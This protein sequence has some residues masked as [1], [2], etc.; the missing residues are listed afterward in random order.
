MYI[1]NKFKKMVC[2]CF[3]LLN[4]LSHEIKK[5]VVWMTLN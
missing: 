4:G 2:I 3:F 1:M 5:N